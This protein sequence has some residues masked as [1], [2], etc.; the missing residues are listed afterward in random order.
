MAFLIGQTIRDIIVVAVT[1]SNNL[2]TLTGFDGSPSFI[3][4]CPGISLTPFITSADVDA[5][6]TTSISL[7]G[8][9]L[10]F[11]NFIQ[12]NNYRDS[13]FLSIA[14]TLSDV[15]A[16][17]YYF[18][19]NV[20]DDAC[21]YNGQAQSYYSVFVLP[22]TNGYCLAQSTTQLS[23]E[24]KFSVYPNPA[25][26]FVNIKSSLNESIIMIEVIDASGKMIKSC[27][28]YSSAIFKFDLLDIAKGS[29]I[30]HLKTE[31]SEEFIRISKI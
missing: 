18:Y 30:L 4:A 19:L 20:G 13:V 6:D 10:T 9:L 2:P 17:P 24:N 8:P 27:K 3:L 16:N 1:S 14:P 29:Y 28:S 21:P 15:S 31:K 12:S 11:I 23:L 7:M 22:P 25:E 26:N 5:N